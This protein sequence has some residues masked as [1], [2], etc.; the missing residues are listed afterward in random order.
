MTVF[1]WRLRK[2][3][4][5]GGL[6][7]AFFVLDT[8]AAF[9][10]QPISG[11]VV[12]GTTTQP[13][14]GQRVELL[15][16]GEGMKTASEAVSGPDGSFT[17]PAVENTQTPHLLLRAIYQGVNYNLSVS[18]HE[19]M[20]KPVTLTIYEITQKLDEAK[21]SLP[22]MLAQASGNTLL[23]QQQY[24]L[25]NETN[26]KKTFVNPQGTFLFDTP[27]SALISELSASVVGLAGIP[28]PQKPVARN[29]GGY[30]INYPMKP[31]VNEIRVSYRINYITTQRELR[32]RV[33]YEMKSTRV[34]ILPPDLQVSG[35]GLKPEERDSRTQ[36]AVYEI[37]EIRKGA[38]L[39]LK[40]LGN[41]PEV[42]AN[43]D[44]GSESEGGQPQVKVVRLPNPI[45][46]KKEIILGCLGAFFTLAIVY[47]LRQ[48]S[49]RTDVPTAGKKES[50]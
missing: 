10:Q 46:E 15:T 20:E 49:R 32:H 28:L 22:A 47:A 1:A 39:D 23:V 8:V 50:S 25:G 42:S 35:T 2:N 24:L 9:A 48:R 11:L 19:E 41:A 40:I 36:A 6:W 4:A 38:F 26:P 31:G 37:A 21:V 29:E 17:F 18:S 33:F 43:D 3:T 14:V 12:N 16:L 30:Q 34:L 7:V 45:F 13:A 44:S 5:L 27:P